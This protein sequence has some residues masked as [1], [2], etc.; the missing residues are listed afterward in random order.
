MATDDAWKADE[1]QEKSDLVEAS[2][3]WKVDEPQEKSD[4]V[5]GSDCLS[6]EGVESQLARRSDDVN[7]RCPEVGSID[8]T[9]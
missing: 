2:D 7:V 8:G 5:E 6:P 3:A 4:L 9:E 1:S